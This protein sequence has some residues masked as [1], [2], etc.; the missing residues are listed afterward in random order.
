M[1]PAKIVAL[2]RVGNDPRKRQRALA[3]VG[4]NLRKRQKASAATNMHIWIHERWLDAPAAVR[5]G[6]SP[7][8]VLQRWAS[9]GPRRGCRRQVRSPRWQCWRRVRRLPR[10]LHAGLQRRPARGCD[11]AWPGARRGVHA[12]ACRRHPAPPPRLCRAPTSAPALMPRRAFRGPSRTHPR[13]PGR[14]SSAGCPPTRHPPGCRPS[15][16]VRQG[17]APRGLPRCLSARHGPGSAARSC[18]PPQSSLV[19]IRR[20]AC[21]VPQGRR[22]RCRRPRRPASG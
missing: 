16:A 17:W 6:A 9:Q 2:A 11:R 4:K 1:C 20:S 14:S 5:L 19:P 22:H 10:L 18:P 13:S 12:P 7:I 3:S 21:A 8:P 15:W